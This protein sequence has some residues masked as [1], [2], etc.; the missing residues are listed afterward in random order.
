VHVDRESGRPA[1]LPSRIVDDYGAAGGDR[2]VAQRLRLPG[3]AEYAT[4]TQ[5]WPLRVTDF[6]VLGHVN[7]AAYLEALEELLAARPTTATHR[8]IERVTIEWRGG[9]DAGDVVELASADSDTELRAWL[10]VAGEVRAAMVAAF[11]R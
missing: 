8:H 7:N 4:T 3:P 10:V 1:P 5:R 2:S 6:D 9:I 11:R